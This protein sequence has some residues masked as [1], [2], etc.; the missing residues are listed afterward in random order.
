MPVSSS[1]SSAR[2]KVHLFGEIGSAEI[3]LVEQLKP[4]RPDFGSPADASWSRNSATSRRR[5]PGWCA[6]VGE[7]V[8][9]SALVNPATICPASSAAIFENSGRKSRSLFHREITPDRDDRDRRHPDGDAL[10]DSQSGDE[11]FQLIH[12]ARSASA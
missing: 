9:H 8:L 6:P 11:L 1:P 3:R 12:A 2:W 5:A 10:A 4:I 7:P